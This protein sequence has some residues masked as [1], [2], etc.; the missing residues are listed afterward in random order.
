M[1]MS[2][3]FVFPTSIISLPSDDECTIIEKKSKQHQQQQLPTKINGR[4]R[5]CYR[6]KRVLFNS[7]K[8]FLHPAIDSKSLEALPME[9]EVGG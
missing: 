8:E 5:E 9:R 3:S 4:A 1:G 6:W 7:F 2:G